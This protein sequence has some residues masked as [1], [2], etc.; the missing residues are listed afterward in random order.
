MSQIQVCKIW[1]TEQ[2]PPQ[3]GQKLLHGFG[4]AQNETEA[5]RWF[6]LSSQR[7]HPES[8]YNLAVGH[9]NGVETDLED[10]EEEDLLRQAARLGVAGADLVLERLCSGGQCLGEDDLGKPSK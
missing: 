4:V 2:N 1:K 8:S 5:M 7:G 9:L 6:R 3:V 10:G